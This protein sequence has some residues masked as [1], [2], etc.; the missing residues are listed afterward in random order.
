MK[1]IQEVLDKINGIYANQDDRLYE[2]EDIIYY[3]QKFLLRFFEKKAQNDKTGMTECLH[4]ASTWFITLL[5]RFHIDLERNLAKRYSYKCPFCLEMPC[6]CQGKGLPQKTG[7]PVS[8]QP[9]TLREWQELIAKIYPQNTNNLDFDILLKQDRLHHLFRHF[10]KQMGKT[11]IKDIETNCA[12]YYV[13][14]LREFNALGLDA[15][16]VFTQYYQDGCYVCHQTPCQC[17]YSE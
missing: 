2:L 1:T 4:S 5:N 12:D 11:L 14:I 9:Q 17:F 3:H 10:R 16:K 15:A 8:R 6:V 7:R 13:S